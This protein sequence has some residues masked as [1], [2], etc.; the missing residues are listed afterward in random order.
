MSFG[1]LNHMF[2]VQEMASGGDSRLKSYKTRG[3]NVEEVRRKRGEEGIQLRKS[4]REDQVCWVVSSCIIMSPYV[5]KDNSVYYKCL[6]LLFVQSM[7]NSTQRC[8]LS[9]A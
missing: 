1:T 2:V 8:Q 5:K 3:L 9:L 6:G 4:K 7:S